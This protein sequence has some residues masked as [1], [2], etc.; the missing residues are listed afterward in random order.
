MGVTYP[1]SAFGGATGI[2]FVNNSNPNRPEVYQLQLFTGTTSSNVAAPTLISKALN[3][4][5]YAFDKAVIFQWGIYVLLCFQQIRNGATDPYNSR[6]LI[7]NMKSGAWDMLDYPCSRLAEYEGTLISGDPLS[8]NI[9]TLFSGFD[10]DGML[11]SNYW[12]SGQTNHGYAGQKVTHRFVVDGL[13]QK[14]QNIDVSFSYDGG[15]FVKAF[16]ISGTGAYVDSGKSI[17]VGSYVEGSKI[18]GGGGSATVYA[19]PF[20]VEFPLNTPRYEYIRVKFEATGGGYAQINFYEY[21]DNR[22][23]SAR[24]MPERQSAM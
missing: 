17:A 7:Y 6:M 23:K 21:K 3:L 12:T 14:S 18:V 9:F 15:N 8:N 5:S 10:D 4:S 22:Y 11:I 1:Y 16:T 24:V 19:N 13:M 2:W 20:Q